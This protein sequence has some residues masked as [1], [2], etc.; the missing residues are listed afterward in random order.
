MEF[1]DGSSYNG[2]LFNGRFQGEGLYTW[3]NGNYY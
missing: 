3:P 1:P 2:E